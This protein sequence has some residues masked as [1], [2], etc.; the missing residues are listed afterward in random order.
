[1]HWTNGGP[2]G[3][4]I[5]AGLLTE[6]G[7]SFLRLRTG[8]F[9]SGA[10]NAPAASHRWLRAE[11]GRAERAHDVAPSG[12]V[13]ACGRGARFHAEGAHDSNAEGVGGVR[14]DQLNW[15]LSCRADSP[16]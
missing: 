13:V 2:G 1:M 4:G 11:V 12:H 15:R 10:P 8:G 6:M 16:Q 7:A 14:R 3:S 5:N 9:S